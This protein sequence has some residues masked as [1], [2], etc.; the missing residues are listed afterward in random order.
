MLEK[1]YIYNKVYMLLLATF[2]LVGCGS[3]KLVGEGKTFSASNVPVRSAFRFTDINDM[4]LST[5]RK[6]GI[7]PIADRREA[8]KKVRKLKHVKDTKLYKL[9][10]MTH[11]IPYLSDGAEKLL[12]TIGKRFQK[13]LHK[14]GYRCHRIIATS[15]LRT[16]DDVARLRKVNG[17]AS[18]NS[19]HLYGTTFDLSYVRF[20]RIDMKG[21]PVNNTVMANVLGEVLAELRDEERCYVRFESN[22][23]CFH[24]T[25]R[26]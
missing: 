17:N 3:S 15:M 24:I 11:S 2:I 6:N 21:N 25:S 13:K 10:N 18:K 19:A 22:Q 8:R 14:R 5:A 26:K 7:E 16:K 12:K 1:H 9:D 23:H 20:N 4:Q